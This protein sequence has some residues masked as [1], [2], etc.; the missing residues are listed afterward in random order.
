MLIDGEQV[1]DSDGSMAESGYVEQ[2]TIQGDPDVFD[3]AA[4][5]TAI[6]GQE[7]IR[8]DEERYA[9]GIPQPS[10][11]SRGRRLVIRHRFGA[12]LRRTADRIDPTPAPAC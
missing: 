2:A 11:P 12:T 3:P 10:R 7:R 5:G 9:R 8:R 6:I 1:L 4:I